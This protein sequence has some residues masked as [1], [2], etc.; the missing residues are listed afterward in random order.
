MNEKLFFSGMGCTA[1]GFLL[2]QVA[3]TNGKEPS[4]AVPILFSLLFGWI[5]LTALSFIIGEKDNNK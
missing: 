1:G 3:A 5:V 2:A 4:W